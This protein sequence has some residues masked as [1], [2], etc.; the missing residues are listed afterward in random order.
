MTGR[1]F[2]IHVAAGVLE[3][4]RERLARTRWPAEL[5]GTGWRQG[6]D[7]V[8]LR[9]LCGY[10]RTGYDW[11]RH[12]A[13]INRFPQFM[14]PVDGIDLHVIHVRGKGPDPAPLLMLHGWPGS[15]IEL[16]GLIGPLT[17]PVAH[18]LPASPS[19]DVVIPALPGFGFSGKPLVSG[20]GANRVAAALDTLMR[21]SLGYLRY[22]V[23]GGDWGTILARRMARNHGDHVSAIHINMAYSPPPPGV[24]PDARAAARGHDLT[25]YLHLQNTRADTLTTG[26]SDSPAGLAAW[27]IEKFR[28]WSD[29][30]GDVEKAFNRDMLLTNLM[31]YWAPNSIA[32]AT[33][34]YWETAAE[35]DDVWGLPR[36]ETPTGVA[37]FPK[38]PYLAPRAWVERLYDVRRWTDMPRGGHFAALEQ[39][40][41][42][43][44]DIRSFFA[45]YT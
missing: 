6:A 31:F 17:D 21:D 26:L 12:E 23:H 38:E 40:Q 16:V 39:P 44:D 13:G 32:S 28:S 11:R 1:P 18:G 22:F 45:E 9:E 10:W 8:Y 42:L 7:L 29:C 3:D 5:P 20:W 41:L 27:V 35:G 30:D 37:A 19:F 25:G 33:R 24:A 14:V 36:V 43:A 34:I 4:L 15:I 2:E